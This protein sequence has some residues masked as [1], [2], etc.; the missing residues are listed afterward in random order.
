MCSDKKHKEECSRR[1][2]RDKADD[3]DFE[4]NYQRQ[5]EINSFYQYRTPVGFDKT[6]IIP[7]D[8]IQIENFGL[9]FDDARMY[10]IQEIEEE[11]LS[12]SGRNI[13]TRVFVN[14][15]MKMIA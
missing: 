10:S 13:K 9:N 4:N 11:F 7:S 2:F 14:Q 8:T 3:P 1:L 12:K 6:F 15:F 5:M